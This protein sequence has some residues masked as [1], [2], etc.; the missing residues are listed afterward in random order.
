MYITSMSMNVTVENLAIEYILWVSVND[1]MVG[2]RSVGIVTT[3]FLLTFHHLEE[4][5]TTRAYHECT[6]WYNHH[7]SC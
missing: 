2:I 6:S 4:E 5:G 7:Y 3:P 1:F